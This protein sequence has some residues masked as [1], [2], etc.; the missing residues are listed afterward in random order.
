MVEVRTHATHDDTRW[1]MMLRDRYELCVINGIKWSWVVMGIFICI[2][3]IKPGINK[4]DHQTKSST[5]INSSTFINQNLG[6]HGILYIYIVIY[7]YMGYPFDTTLAGAGFYVEQC[8]T[9]SNYLGYFISRYW[10][11]WCGTKSLKGHQSQALILV[12]KPS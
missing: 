10:L 3:Q 5:I 9:S 12:A 11:R 2:S 6:L 1:Y 8:F 4:S 7:N